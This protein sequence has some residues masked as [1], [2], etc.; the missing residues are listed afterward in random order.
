MHGRR[1]LLAALAA[2]LAWAWAALADDPP[3][4][5]ALPKG[6]TVS[7]DLAYVANGH[8]RQKLDLY[9]PEK[10]A[11]APLPVILWIHG[12]AWRQD[13]KAPTPAVPFATRG[14]ALAS[15][16]YRLS[17]DA[18]FPAQIHDCKAAI[19][20]LRANARKYN[21]DSAHIGVWGHS[22]GGHLVSL[23]GTSGDVKELEG[24]EGNLDQSSRVQAVVDF[25]G[26]ADL[27]RTDPSG[28]KPK[29]NDGYRAFIGGPLLDLQDIAK[30]ASPLTYVS[31]NSPPFLIVHGTTDKTVLP[32]QGEW[33]VTALKHA[34][35]DATLEYVAGAGHDMRQVQTPAIAE[36]VT[37]FFDKHLRDGKRT[38]DDANYI[39][40]PPD[41]WQD[42]FTDE[43]GGLLYKT[44]PQPSRGTKMR[45][46][47]RLYLPPDYEANPNRRYPVIYWLH[48]ASGDSR[49]AINHGWVPR[50]DAAIRNGIA[51]PIIAILVESPNLS[52]YVDSKDGKIPVETVIVKDLIAH[53]DSTYRTI[54]TREGRA[55][56]GQSMGGAGSLRIGFNHPELFGTV[57]ST[58][59]G[60]VDS[61]QQARNTGNNERL[62]IMYSGDMDYYQASTAWA[63]VE[64][65][66]DKIRGRTNIR[67]IVGDNDALMAR[68]QWFHEL[69]TRL[70]IQH[71]FVI[72][73]GAI[74]NLREELSRLDS[75]PFEFYAKAF[76]HAK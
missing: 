8:A 37:G 10:K 35:V 67:M 59:A 27:L 1:L 44:Y 16:N 41:C 17:F 7:R 32:R 20:W 75:N 42:P 46:S 13:D 69:L 14:Y 61:S 21:L 60:I 73:K 26:P 9:L 64:K 22:S 30:A 65:N 23:L 15:I 63:I 4:A 70:N 34:G 43:I 68:N 5:D 25:S 29:D 3:P 19:R 49:Q 24:S 48:G 36:D 55:I 38:R 31:S 72:S 12:G 58:A 51:P 33:F 28:T 62:R 39:V 50:L 66:A 40:E 47:Y 74:H 18:K 54:A 45:G 11:E 6:V 56:D 57:S 2:L 53:V 52:G 71:Q 76:A